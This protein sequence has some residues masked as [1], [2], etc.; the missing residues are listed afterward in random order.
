MSTEQARAVVAR[1][2]REE[3]AAA[4]AAALVSWDDGQGVDQQNRRL[5]ISSMPRIADSHLVEV[6]IWDNAIAEHYAATDDEAAVR[7]IA[8]RILGVVDLEN[9]T[10]RAPFFLPALLRFDRCYSYLPVFSLWLHALRQPELLHG[11]MPP[12]R[13]NALLK[14]V[15]ACCAGGKAGAAPKL[16]PLDDVAVRYETVRDALE[17]HYHDKEHGPPG[18]EV[19][20]PKNSL[21][22]QAGARF[23]RGVEKL[24]FLFSM[25][26]GQAR[27]DEEGADLLEQ[28]QNMVPEQR[29][30][31]LDAT[32]LAILTEWYADCGVDEETVRSR[33]KKER[34]EREQAAQARPI[35]E[36][37]GTRDW[38]VIDEWVRQRE[39]DGST[40]R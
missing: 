29:P 28:L 17:E 26:R 21:S 31:S 12:S 38:A 9:E 35:E 3:S 39:A 16:P 1:Y 10:T 37:A 6:G 24:V 2:F 19:A 33:L 30:R 32:V 13:A 4:R 14:E 22:I 18:P 34:R 25:D 23:L 5:I 40:R 15:L 20:P 7:R 36:T 11:M 27:S 8:H